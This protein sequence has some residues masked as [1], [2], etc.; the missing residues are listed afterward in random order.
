VE[1]C[2]HLSTRTKEANAQL[3]PSCDG[4]LLCGGS[5]KS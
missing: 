4:E 3:L 5:A 1:S 2:H